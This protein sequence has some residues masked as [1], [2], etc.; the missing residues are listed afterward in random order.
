MAQHHQLNATPA[1][2]RISDQQAVMMPSDA[3]EIN[4]PNHDDDDALLHLFGNLL[5]NYSHSHTTN[6]RL[7]YNYDKSSDFNNMNVIPDDSLT[8]AYIG[9][10]SN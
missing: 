2:E 10:K 8:Q 9:T 5:D 6:D 3:L 1:K 7:R 4:E